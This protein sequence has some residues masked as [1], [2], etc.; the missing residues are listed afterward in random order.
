M[1]GGSFPCNHAMECNGHL[2]TVT[3]IFPPGKDIATKSARTKLLM[4]CKSQG[5]YA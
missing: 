1:T 5:R 2:P 4:V 3:A